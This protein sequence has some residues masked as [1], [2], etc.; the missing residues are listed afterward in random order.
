MKIGNASN[1]YICKPLLLVGWPS[2]YYREPM[3]VFF[4]IA[5]MDTHDGM[6]G[7]SAQD[8]IH[9]DMIFVLYISLYTP[10]KFNSSPLKNDGWR[11]ISY[12]VSETFQGLLLM[13]EIVHQ[14]IVR[15][16]DF[17][18]FY[19]SQVGKLA[20]FLKHQQYVCST[21]GVYTKMNQRWAPELCGW[22]VLA[23]NHQASFVKLCW[24]AKLL[25][26]PHNH[27]KGTK[28]SRQANWPRWDT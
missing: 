17:R 25:S 1:R 21:S 23:R 9:F 2:P 8:C 22:W 11:T 10:P 13:E 4:T 28:Q 18:G 7:W 19:T 5:H 27:G 15:S 26:F 24:P 20:G 6:Y 14:L 16:H 3:G 12:W